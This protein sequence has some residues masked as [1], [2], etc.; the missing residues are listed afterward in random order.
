MKV[1]KR[2]KKENLIFKAIK[3]NSNDKSDNKFMLYF[4]VHSLVRNLTLK[5]I[6]NKNVLKFINY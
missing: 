5:K 6:K 1:L 4:V 3:I 2:K